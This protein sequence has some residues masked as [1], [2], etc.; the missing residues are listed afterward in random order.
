MVVVLYDFLNLSTVDPLQSLINSAD[1]IFKINQ[2]PEH[3]G[4]F[5]CNIYS[6][7]VQ[8]KPY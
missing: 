2:I 6:W 5:H 4:T 3:L 7:S 1:F 8:I